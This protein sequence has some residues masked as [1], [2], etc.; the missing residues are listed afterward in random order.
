MTV[1]KEDE[2]VQVK[3]RWKPGHLL[4]QLTRA[5][6]HEPLAASGSGCCWSGQH[7]RLM[8]R[9]RFTALSHAG[10]CSSGRPGRGGREQ[11]G[12]ELGVRLLLKSV[13][14]WGMRSLCPSQV[15]PLGWALKPWLRR[16]CIAPLWHR[17]GTAPT[18]GRGGKTV[19]LFSWKYFL[20][21]NEGKNPVL[22]S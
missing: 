22:Q 21:G 8:L 10:I 7:F 5:L 3:R 13:D 11:R 20:Q 12:Q 19:A 16:H 6:M 14:G 2:I 15:Q 1:F 17:A 4:L 18:G 9:I